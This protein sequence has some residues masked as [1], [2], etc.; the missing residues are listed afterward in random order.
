[1]GVLAP[2]RGLS[3]DRDG[4]MYTVVF[5]ERLGVIVHDSLGL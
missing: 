4:A 2:G 3:A 1:V 5:L